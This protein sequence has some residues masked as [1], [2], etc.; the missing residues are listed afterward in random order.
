[1]VLNDLRVP[2][3]W[4]PRWILLDQKRIQMNISKAMV[5]P[6]ESDCWFLTVECLDNGNGSDDD[7][8]WE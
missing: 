7:Y 1:M 5:Q 8:F 4:V 2:A 3:R 6:N